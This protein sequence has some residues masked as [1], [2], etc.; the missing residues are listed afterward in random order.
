[1]ARWVSHP[2][3][4]QFE[5]QIEVN[6]RLVLIQKATYRNNGPNPVFFGL[7]TN[8]EMMVY[9]LQYT[10]GDLIDNPAQIGES[11][12]NSSIKLFPN[13]SVNSFNIEFNSELFGETIVEIRDLGGKLIEQRKLNLNQGHQ[14]IPINHSLKS[15][16]YFVDIINT[17][18]SF[19]KKLIVN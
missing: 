18:K 6:P 17:S 15:G 8:D 9:Y 10:L 11:P 7:T 13:P 12:E 2:P 4:R 16:F 3:I 1:M 14:I 19:R 5:P